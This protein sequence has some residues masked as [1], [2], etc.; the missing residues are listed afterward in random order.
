MAVALPMKQKSQKKKKKKKTEG[1]QCKI[2]NWCSVSSCAECYG[3]CSLY[4]WKLRYSLE[5]YIIFCTCSFDAWLTL[6]LQQWFIC[7]TM[8]APWV[9][10]SGKFFPSPTVSAA[11][12]SGIRNIWFIPIHIFNMHSH[13]HLNNFKNFCAEEWSVNEHSAIYIHRISS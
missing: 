2:H 9:W 6:G 1:F 12:H 11:P 3:N 4:I 13:I 7:C 8:V 5:L 10:K